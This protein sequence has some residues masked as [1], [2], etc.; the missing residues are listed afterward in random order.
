MKVSFKTENRSKG[1]FRVE[2]WVDLILR[3]DFEPNELQSIR[4]LEHFPIGRNR[5]GIH[6]VGEQ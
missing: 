5:K 4:K 2:E 1:F 3:I 6:K